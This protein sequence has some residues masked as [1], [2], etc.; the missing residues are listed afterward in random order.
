LLTLADLMVCLSSAMRF[1][2]KPA[3]S[4]KATQALLSYI[5]RG[6]SLL[7]ESQSG[8]ELAGG[9][10]ASW[11]FPMRC[12]LSL[13]LWTCSRVKHLVLS[14]PQSNS[15]QLKGS[16]TLQKWKSSWRTKG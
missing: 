14:L 6:L 5:L 13:S 2:A 16:K 4:K 10:S 15:L 12:R 3:S 1:T 9:E 8:S 7:M 11:S